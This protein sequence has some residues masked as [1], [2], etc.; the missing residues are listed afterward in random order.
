MLSIGLVFFLFSV[1][2]FTQH[3]TPPIFNRITQVLLIYCAILSLNILY[4]CQGQG[5]GIFNGLF[6]VRPLQMTFEAFIFICAT[7][8]V[9]SF[10]K[11]ISQGNQIISI[12]EY[13]I[14]IIF[15][16]YGQCL[17]IRRSDLVSI[18]LSIELQSF[19]IYVIATLYRKRESRTIAGLKYFLLGGLSSAIILLGTALIY[20]YT[21]LTQFEDIYTLCQT[22]GGND[23]INPVILGFSLI[24]IGFLFKIASAP[25]HNWAPDV[26]DG[27]PT[28]AT[29]FLQSIP[30][31]SIFL[32]LCELQIGL[33]GSFDSL[34]II[35]DNSS[36]DIWKNLLLYARLS[37]LCLGTVL[38]LSQYRIKRLLAYSTISHVGFILLCLQVNSQESIQ[39]FLFYIV[40]YSLTN[41]CTFLVVLA[42]QIKLIRNN[43]EIKDIEIIVE[44]KNQFKNEPILAFSISICLFSIA[45]IPPLIGFFAKQIVLSSC[46]SKGYYFICFLCVIVSVISAVYYLKIVKVLYFEVFNKNEDEKEDTK[47]VNISFTHRFSI[48]IL[49]IIITFF[50]FM[51]QILLNTSNILA[52]IIFNF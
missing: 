39:T 3:I 18:Y 47:I 33:L 1:P 48:A 4:I 13:P 19:A 41:I 46:I 15:A 35:Q 20:R 52:L 16:V 6:Q 28:Y 36:I 17:L 12:K 5:L 14:I 7:I 9:F 8:I 31:I 50:I 38:G 34:R 24:S 27:V 40:Q 21:G 43:K 42:F 30:K 49:T 37:S 44:L 32:F 23:Y 45:G 51:P 22:L 2:L 25:L 26:Y 11:N 10:H 29:I